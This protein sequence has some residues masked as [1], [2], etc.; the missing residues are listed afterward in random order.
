MAFIK[1]KTMP[2]FLESHKV[3]EWTYEVNGLHV[4]GLNVAPHQPVKRIVIYLRGGKGQVGRVRLAR[5]LQF[6]TLDTLVFAPYITGVKA[7]MILQVQIWRML[8]SQ[9]TC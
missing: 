5:L 1:N 3:E 7:T 8:R 9:Q 6:I 2:V 4:K